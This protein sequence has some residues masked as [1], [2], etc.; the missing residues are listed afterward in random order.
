MRPNYFISIAQNNAAPKGTIHDPCSKLKVKVIDLVKEKFKPSKGEVRY[1][2][3]A[4]KETLAFETQGYKKHRNLL[5]LHMIAKYCLY[6][7]LL[8]EAR[9]HSTLPYLN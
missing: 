3:T 2:V 4:G 1:F 8:E 6:L 5:I 9:I 7:G